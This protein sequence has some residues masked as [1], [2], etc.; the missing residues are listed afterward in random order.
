MSAPVA[1]AY[2]TVE[3]GV[4]SLSL[5]FGP[6][7]GVPMDHTTLTVILPPGSKGFE[8]DLPFSQDGDTYRLDTLPASVAFEAEMPPPVGLYLLVA[9]II[10]LA[11]G[12][13]WYW[14]KNQ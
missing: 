14:R 9:A 13:V 8:S 7:Y 4:A 6:L 3:E 12:A 2:A 1:R 11:A 5:G 10:I